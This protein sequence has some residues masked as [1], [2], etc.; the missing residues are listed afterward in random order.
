MMLRT[1]IIIFTSV[2][3][4]L[5]TTALLI[6]NFMTQLEAE[7]RFE[8]AIISSKTLLWNKILSNQMAL[9]ESE[10]GSITRDRSVRQ[11]IIKKDYQTLSKNIT[12]TFRRLTTSNTLTHLMILDSDDNVIFNAPDRN[13]YTLNNPLVRQAKTSGKIVRGL[14]RHA[15]GSMLIEVAFPLYLRGKP[16]GVGV[17]SRT[18]AGAINEFKLSDNS[19]ALIIKA[20]GNKE[21]STNDDFFQ[22]IKS[23]LPT[24]NPEAYLTLDVND[25]TFAMV[26]TPL[27]TVSGSTN[28]YLVTASDYSTSYSA[29]SSVRFTSLS[30][31]LGILI[32]S[33]IL[34]NLYIRHAFKPLALVINQMEQIADG[35]L[36][37]SEKPRRSDEIGQLLNAMISMTEQL[38]SI[39][40]KVREMSASLESSTNDLK[41][42]AIETTMGMQTQLT[43]TEQVA[44]ATN[45]MS[46]TVK[47]IATH[48]EEA[49]ASAISADQDAK[50]GQS[51]VA[52]SIDSINEMSH[53]IEQ[54]SE[55]ISKLEQRSTD[56]GSVLDVIRGIAEQTNLLA[57]NAAIESARAGE[58]GR[59]FA[60][61]ADEVR[62]L[63]SRTQ[64]STE[65]IQEMIQALQEGTSR[66]VRN[67]ALNISN[68]RHNVEHSNST[69]KSLQTIVASIGTINTMNIQISHAAQS[70]ADVTEEINRNVIN[71]N[72]SAE[73]CAAKAC[74]TSW[75]SEKISEMSKELNQLVD[76]FNVH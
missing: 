28:G 39:I 24:T 33:L 67:M 16:I 34:C 57:L 17:F 73:L 47:E 14:N 51:I 66:A 74:E 59:G 46:S 31:A 6:S 21:I 36:V 40:S 20:N 71:I 53:N 42:L 4:L 3:V 72:K 15:D 7:Q 8:S 13:L 55:I 68:V 32:V 1:R 25:K 75:Y 65:D 11:A 61:V 35:N 37:I 9:M 22:T 58:Q 30:I 44:V 54:S 50:Q 19:E 12:T 10:V 62:T 69:E 49:A 48:A 5:I 27:A 38:R 41:Q 45:Q 23:I 43:E 52:T 56:I 29:Q 63:A 2:N 60:V 70:Q 64:Q 76:H 18:L 26:F